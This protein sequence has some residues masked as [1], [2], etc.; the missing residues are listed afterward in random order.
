[1]SLDSH[2]HR[3]EYS[4]LATLLDSGDFAKLIEKSRV[5][6][7]WMPTCSEVFWIRLLAKNGCKNDIELIQKGINCDN[8]ADF[9]NAY[10]Y[11][12]PAEKATYDNVKNLIETRDGIRI[13]IG[14][15][16]ANEVQ[17]LTLGVGGSHHALIAGVAGSGKSSLLHTIILRTLTQ[18]S[19]D[20]LSIYLVDFK[21]KL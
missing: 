9:Y 21:Y 20:E 5:V 4:Q 1:M 13:P 2:K 7:R 16:G 3:M 11:G 18:Y 19:P 15:H 12:T 14:I 10:R 6:L 17:Y 8:S